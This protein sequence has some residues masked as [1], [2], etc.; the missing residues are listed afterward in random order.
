MTDRYAVIGNPVGHSKSPIIHAEFAR[1]TG[2]DIEYS[3]VLAPLDGF[4]AAVEE[5][6]RCGGKGLNVTLPFKLEAYRLAT[7][8]SARAT[9][10]E[11][12]NVLSFD[13]DSI[14]GDNTDG[15]GLVRDIET[16][17]GFPLADRRVLLLG[18]GG[19]AQGALGPLLAARPAILAVGNRTAEKAQRLVARFTSSGR[20]PGT[21]LQAGSFHSYAGARFDLVVNAT[22]ASLKDTAPD[23]PMGLFA[24]E[25]MA[26]DM[27]YG[28]GLTPF[29]RLAQQQGAARLADGLGMLVEQAAESFLIWR[30]IRPDTRPVIRQLQSL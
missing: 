15:I 2:Q 11:A 19:A 17:L 22:S 30:G 7:Q 27:M 20:F 18:A 5:F 1:Q 6:R 28:Q 4:G 24:A 10:A 25:S 8:R 12:V 29:L 13:R 23:I 21:A 3:R 16:N 26:Y 14:Q 9:D